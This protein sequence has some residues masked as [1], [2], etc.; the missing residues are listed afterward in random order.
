MLNEPYAMRLRLGLR[1]LAVAL[2]TVSV[3]AFTLPQ[4]A[5]ADPRG[6]GMHGQMGAHDFAGRALH[7]LLRHKKDLNLSDEQVTKIKAIAVDYAKNKIRGD[8][9]VKLAEVDVYALVFD[10]KAD[11]GAIEGAMKKSEGAQTAVR[12]ERVKALRAAGEVLT[13]EQREQWR[14]TMRQGRHHGEGR[15]GDHRA[16]AEEPEGSPEAES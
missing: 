2:A 9:E 3:L 13:P 7:G 10:E 16:Q 5:N 6:G 8:A 14:A 15:H 1:V 12:L 4:P 11:I